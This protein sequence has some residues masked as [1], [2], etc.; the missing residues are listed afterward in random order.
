MV[1]RGARHTPAAAANQTRKNAFLEWSQIGLQGPSLSNPALNK[2]WCVS[3]GQGLVQYR[4]AE[5]PHPMALLILSQ[6]SYCMCD[7]SRRI[8]F[9]P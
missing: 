4:I 8:A 9:W 3:Y 5:E 6:S 2:R 1:S 7:V